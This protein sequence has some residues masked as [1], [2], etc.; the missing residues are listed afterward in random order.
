MIEYA[1]NSDQEFEAAWL[2]TGKRLFKVAPS[3]L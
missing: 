3:V 1:K 2:L